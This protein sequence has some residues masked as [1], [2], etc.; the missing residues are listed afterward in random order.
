MKKLMLLFMIVPV[1]EIIIYVK[2]G[3]YIGVVPTLL[4]IILTGVVGV[5]LARQQGISTFLKAREEMTAGRVPGSEI[6]DG[7]IIFAGAIFLLTPGLITDIT[8]F[9][10]LI[11]STRKIIRRFLKKIIKRWIDDGRAQIFFRFR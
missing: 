10:F 7:L 6:L 4:T 11:P 2:L 8:G 9:I 1:L 5:A 3:Q